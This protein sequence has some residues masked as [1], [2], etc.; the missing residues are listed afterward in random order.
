MIFLSD[1]D[2]TLIFSYKKMSPESLCVETKEGKR[3]SY[4]THEGGRLFREM[5][6][7][8]RFIPITTRSAEQYSR[9]TFPEGY[10]PEFALTANGASLLVKGVPDKEWTEE[11]A[12]QI[13]AC[14]PEF[15]ALEKFLKTCP[16][17]CFDIRIVDSAFLFTKCKNADEAAAR[18]NREIS[19]T[20]TRLY[21]NG[22]KLYALPRTLGK[23]AALKR[24]KARFPHERIIAA[25][26]SLFDEEMLR[27]ADIA[28]VK[29]GELTGKRLNEIQLTEMEDDPDFA[30]RSALQAANMS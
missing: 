20:L 4:M 8:M 7:Q 14:K 17:V 26:D 5:T 11:V 15:A 25:G 30:L 21:T 24:L 19:P 3:L 6:K 18:M 13:A 1:L 28:I 12:A 27:A 22:E 16:E 9:I 2:N 10:I 23:E 29:K